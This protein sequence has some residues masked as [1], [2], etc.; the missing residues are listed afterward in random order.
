MK[1]CTKCKL[2]KNLAEFSLNK[3]YKDGY[4]YHCKLCRNTYQKSYS[5]TEKGK[6]TTRKNNTKRNTDWTN[7]NIIYSMAKAYCKQKG[8][9][10]TLSKE[11]YLTLY[12][13]PCHYCNNILCGNII[14]KGVS[15][16]RIDN[17][18]GYELD[19]VLPCGTFCNRTRGDRLTVQEM[20]D[21][22]QFIISKR[23]NNA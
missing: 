21:V 20:L 13:L 4:N 14:K 19:N 11:E 17:S 16:D 23:T 1:K 15:L 12:H 5:K 18:R 9:L 7:P 2:E 22:A 6:E 3:K 8:R 10:F